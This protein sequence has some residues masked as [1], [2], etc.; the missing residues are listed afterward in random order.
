MDSCWDLRINTAQQDVTSSCFSLFMFAY[1]MTARITSSAVIL[2]ADWSVG[3]RHGAV[4]TMQ[5]KY[6]TPEI[7]YHESVKKISVL[8]CCTKIPTKT[9]PKVHNYAALCWLLLVSYCPSWKRFTE[10]TE[11]TGLIVG[12][13]SV[14]SSCHPPLV[15][16]IPLM[17][18]MII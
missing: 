11:R 2:D 10:L 17:N 4:H 9:R 5:I 13:I 8:W 12:D 18:N 7:L 1:V 3:V 16:G 6:K 15:I 14:T